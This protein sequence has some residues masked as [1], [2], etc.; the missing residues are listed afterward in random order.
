L[1]GGVTRLGRRKSPPELTS[2]FFRGRMI[3]G[4]VLSGRSFI[5]TPPTFLFFPASVP[6]SA[7]L[8]LRSVPLCELLAFLWIMPNWF[9]PAKEY[10]ISC[11]GRRPL[12]TRGSSIDFYFPPQSAPFV[13][14][15]LEGPVARG[16]PLLGST[17]PPLDDFFTSRA[18]LEKLRIARVTRIWGREDLLL[19]SD[20]HARPPYASVG[21]LFAAA[22]YVIADPVRL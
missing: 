6:R 20:D 2:G 8:G 22:P 9:P 13:F 10:A 7:F 16:F 18:R 4:F 12:L 19:V 3:L 15:F 11:F 5:F 1:L 21:G 14:S 17:V